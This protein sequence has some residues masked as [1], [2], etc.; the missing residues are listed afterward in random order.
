M[1][2]DSRTLIEQSKQLIATARGVIDESRKIRAVSE[3][4]TR[5][6]R[7]V[8]A[9]AR[10]DAIASAAIAPSQSRCGT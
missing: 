1:N 3:S 4:N 10:Q 9:L 7:Q 8:L 5:Y 2:L 6:A